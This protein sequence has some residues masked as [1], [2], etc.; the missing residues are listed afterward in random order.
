MGIENGVQRMKKGWREKLWVEFERDRGV[1]VMT[2]AKDDD[3][4]TEPFKDL[5]ELEIDN[6]TASEENLQLFL[7]HIRSP[8]GKNALKRLEIVKVFFNAQKAEI[9]AQALSLP[10]CTIEELVFDK[11]RAKSTEMSLIFGALAQNKSVASLTLKF[12]NIPM[13]SLTTMVN[14]FSVNHTLEML[15]L[16]NMGLTDASI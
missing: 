7:E 14:M 8:K 9:L 2:T 11:C 10:S 15:T 3:D 13:N 5:K 4:G 6:H 12:M 1:S 16:Y